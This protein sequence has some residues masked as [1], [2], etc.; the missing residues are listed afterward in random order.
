MLLA[1]FPKQLDLDKGQVEQKISDLACGRYLVYGPG[2]SRSH[3][4]EAAEAKGKKAAVQT[5]EP[6]RRLWE[7]ISAQKNNH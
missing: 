3:A 2:D 6:A 1:N 5:L 7:T 4:K